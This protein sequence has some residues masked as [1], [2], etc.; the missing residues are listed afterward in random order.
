LEAGA[1]PRTLAS[2]A[3]A[4]ALLETAGIRPSRSMGQ[5]FLVDANILR[6]ISEAAGLAPYDTVIEVGAGLGALTQVLV[7]ECGKVYALESD[8]RLIGILEHELGGAANLVLVEA[9][10]SRFDLATLWDSEPPAPVKMVSNL[11]Y[12]IAATLLIDCLQQCPWLTEYTVMVQREVADRIACGH[13]GR[14]YSGASVKVQTR[15]EVRR[16]AS[17]SRNSFYPKPAVDS[18]I[19]H[20]A[21][22]DPA[23]L[24]AVVGSGFL[25]RVVTAAFSQRRKKLTN[26]LAG[27]L[28]IDTASVR[29]A[30]EALDIDPG[31]RAEG[32]SPEQFVRLCERL[33]K[34]AGG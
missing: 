13:G 25:D 24:P 33:D 3:A 2:P 4:R 21:R 30:L 32:L 10:A 7:E 5:N 28:D 31:A 1:A 8:S 29:S 11:P 19:L 17:V 22:R 15:A 20:L 34:S 23:S 9:D 16:V 26:S 6:I 12:Q 14:D 18:T 27:G